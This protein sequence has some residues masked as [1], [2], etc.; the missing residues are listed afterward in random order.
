MEEPRWPVTHGEGSRRKPELASHG[1][2]TGEREREE[3]DDPVGE[4]AHQSATQA[5][6]ARAGAF[7]GLSQTHSTRAAHVSLN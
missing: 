5:Q 2:L 7:S 1:V 3:E 6:A 4:E